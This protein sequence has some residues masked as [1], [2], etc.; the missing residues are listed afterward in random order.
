MLD[1]K[2]ELRGKYGSAL[3]FTDELEDG[4]KNQ[5]LELLNQDFI[6]GS[7]VRIM[8][9]VHQ[10]MGCVIGFTANMGDKLIPNIVGVDIGCGMLTVRLGDIEVDFSKLDKIINN[11]IPGGFKIH[12]EIKYPFEKLKDLYC[13]RDLKNTKRIQRSIGTLGGGNH[14]IELGED[15]KTEKYLII[16]SGSRN[17][18]KQVADYYQKIAIDHC[19]GLE[20]Y[21]YERDRIIESYREEGRN[22]EINKVLRELKKKYKPVDLKYPKNLCYLSGKYKDMYL[23]DMRIC[24]EYASLNRKIMAN[25]ILESKF[26]QSIEDFEHFE[27]VHNY[28]DFRDNIVRKGAISAN[29]DELVLIPIN[30]RDG[31]LLARGKGNSNWN[32]SAPHGAGRLMSRNQAHEELSMADF[33]KSMKGIYSSSIRENTL[34]ESPFAYKSIDDILEHTEDTLEII[35]RIK[36]LYNFKS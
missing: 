34:D 16:H 24:Q 11:K 1:S 17:L 27:T 36:P 9:D 26:D 15:S 3:I 32:N 22:K 5:I 8:P 19:S 10:G 21:Y 2:I 12:N 4:S 35:D 30:M 7:K 6:E 20:E 18:G 14:F 33:K 31:S 25:I 29:K 13:Y 28:I 23:H